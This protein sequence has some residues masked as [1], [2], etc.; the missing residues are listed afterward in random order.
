V[1]LGEIGL[2]C[3]GMWLYD[4][5]LERKIPIWVS[6]SAIVIGVA[7]TMVCAKTASVQAHSAS[8]SFFEHLRFPALLSGYGVFATA[9]SLRDTL[10]HIPRWLHISISRLGQLTMGIYFSHVPVKD[11]MY[12]L[13][14]RDTFFLRRC[15]H[16]ME[17]VS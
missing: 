8:F 11:I 2:F 9:L 13:N 16:G 6:I 17:P 7:L 14:F 10:E 3:L 12:S 15:F 5:Y 1:Y 4:V